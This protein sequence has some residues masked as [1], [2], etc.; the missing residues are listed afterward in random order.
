VTDPSDRT[1][2][3]SAHS[4]GRPPRLAAVGLPAAL[5]CLIA[6]VVAAYLVVDGRRSPDTQPSISS[7]AGSPVPSSELEGEWS[8][9]GSLT[10][11]AGFDEGCPGTLSVTLI[12]DCSKKLCAVTPFDRSYGSPPLRFGDGSYRAAGPVPADAAPTCGGAPTHSALW[13]L[14]LIVRDGR[15]SGSYAESTVQGFDCGAT[16]VAWE[17][18]LDRT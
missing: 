9:E 12:I 14:V 18:T 17:F 5:A 6:V 1:S 11:C 7:S 13:R 2:W 15:L 16:G 8:G 10:R 4:T 3:G